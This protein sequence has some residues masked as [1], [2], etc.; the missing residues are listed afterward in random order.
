M[1]LERF[2]ETY[3]LILEN[4]KTVGYK[5][6]YEINDKS[7]NPIVY[8]DVYICASSLNKDENHSLNRLINRTKYTLNDLLELVK[9]GIDQF[10]AQKYENLFKKSKQKFEKTEQNFCIISKSKPDIKIAV[11]MSKNTAYDLFK[12][13][14]KDFHSSKYICFVHTILNE[15]MIPHKDDKSLIIENISNEIQLIV[16]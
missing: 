14:H 16:D 12:E 13:E 11:L 1:A 9:H 5:K 8:K 7:F 2:N 4:F 15:Y 10:F 3:N 6:I